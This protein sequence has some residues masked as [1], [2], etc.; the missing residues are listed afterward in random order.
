VGKLTF[1]P[2]L[3]NKMA[4]SSSLK[5]SISAIID[6]VEIVSADLQRANV[7]DTKNINNRI[8]PPNIQ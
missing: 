7:E 3:H 1:F 6:D 2:A 4:N 8:D 5:L